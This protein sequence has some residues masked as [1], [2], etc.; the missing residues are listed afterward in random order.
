MKDGD[1]IPD[2]LEERKVEGCAESEV[3]VKVKRQTRRK[4]RMKT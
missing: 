3:K 2:V 1:P 4:V